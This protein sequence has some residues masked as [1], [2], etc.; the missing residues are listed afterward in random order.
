MKSK[1]GS[2][3]NYFFLSNKKNIFEVDSLYSDAPPSVRYPLARVL[4]EPVAKIRVI[5]V[6]TADADKNLKCIANFHDTHIQ[7][8]IMP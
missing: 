3:P 2:K 8:N 1:S 6:I 7:T 5:R 4:Y